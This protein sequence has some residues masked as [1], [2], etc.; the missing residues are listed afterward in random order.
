MTDEQS[1]YPVPTQPAPATAVPVTEPGATAAAT[2]PA[3][4][5]GKAKRWLA[6]AMLV[7]VGLVTGG[8]AT[9]ALTSTPTSE[10]PGTMSGYGGPMGGPPGG[11]G[12]SDGTAP[13]QQQGTTTDGTSTT[14][15]QPT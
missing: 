12:Q 6:G 2:A 5:T 8:G 10:V 11:F 3:A 15:G 9:Y 1:P 7:T 4:G 14:D 13:D